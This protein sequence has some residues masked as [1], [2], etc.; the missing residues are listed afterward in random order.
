MRT[1]S[2]AALLLL[3]LATLPARD[4]GPPAGARMPNFNLPDQDGKTHTLKSLLGAKGAVVLVFRSA[5][6]CPY[7]KAQLMDLEKHQDDFHKLELNVA[8]LSYDSPAVL[9][10]FAERKNV[11]FPLLSDRDSKIIRSLGILNESVPK[12]S[13]QY[14]IPHP[15][16]FVL[17]AKGVIK[18][19]Y[20][21]EDDH[22]RYTSAGILLHQFGI[23]PA[24]ERKEI[25]GKQI[26]VTSAASAETVSPGQRIVLTLDLE[27][28]PKMHVYAP[29]VETYIPIEWK[30]KDGEP[31]IA[32]PA[33]F[34]APQKLHL[35]AIGETVPAYSGHFQLVRDINIQDVDKIRPAVNTAGYFTIHSTLRY[36]AC[37]DRICYIPQELP[38]QWTLRYED[39][40]TQRV[41]VELQRKGHASSD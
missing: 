41:P 13:P 36:Q 34:P 29:G 37:D 30:M 6:W 16:V 17:D 15:G 4:F 25:Q 38:I 40:D 33:V 19:K 35:D 3:T 11:H 10:H 24:T 20:F 8:A 31:V 9:H 28:K 18:A 26:A 32:Q 21:D 2:V 22:Q 7:C 27:L 14:G 5:D 12:D 1:S 23:I 39:L